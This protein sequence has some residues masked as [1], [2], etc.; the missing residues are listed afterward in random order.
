[1][2]IEAVT[3]RNY[4]AFGSR[5]ARLP[6]D[7]EFVAVTGVNNSGKT[8]ILRFFYEMRPLFQRI[9][10]AGLNSAHMAR[11]LAPAG[12]EV[13]VPTV[14]AGERI[15]CAGNPSA[16]PR[17]TFEFQSS[18][19]EDIAEITLVLRADSTVHAQLTLGSGQ[20]V[21]EGLPVTT[22]THDNRVH[23][24]AFADANTTWTFDW[25]PVTADLTQ[26]AGAMYV[27]GFRN[28]VNAGGI[29]PYYDLSAGT[30]FIARF[31]QM[32]SGHNHASNEAVLQMC[33][34][35]ADIFGFDHLDVN[36]SPAT[37]ELQF[38]VDNSSF[39]GSELGAGITEF[40]IVAA[41]TLA[42]R[43]TM[44]LIDEPELHLHASLQLRFLSLLARY[45]SGPIV[46]STHSLGLARAAADAVMVASRSSDGTA[47]L[48]D[49]RAVPNLSS[50]LGELGYGGLNDGTFQ[51][52]L[53]VE[54][55]TDVR[56]MHEFLVKLGVR[57]QVVIAPLGGDA[58]AAGKNDFGL[59]EL[60]RLS[61]HVFAIVDSER[62]TEADAAAPRRRAFQRSCDAQGIHCHL[63]ERRSI[64]NYLDLA[65]AR[66]VMSA[67]DATDFGPFD[68]P[69]VEWNWSRERNWR[70]AQQMNQD[71]VAT[72][73]LGTALMAIVAQLNL[74]T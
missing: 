50:I 63:L 40:V 13:G 11:L 65:V 24:Q 61:N 44:L 8:S 48:D 15:R 32:K 70:I 29:D 57:N 12:L 72:T 60:R 16:N 69:G 59:S 27:P 73:D 67:P 17:I 66:E 39:R 21:P 37:D 58:L 20:S 7:H 36:A 22:V 74:D 6:L 10:A 23:L 30:N 35:L 9:A 47:T 45:T 41:N 14:L 19:P 28:A 31:N 62:T 56:V 33:R 3:L 43:P 52:V 42:R 34:E 38:N 54:G 51:A 25:A 71:V 55:V 49:W 18:A 68:A 53:L 64:E 2:T 26:L 4:R 1:M 5:G 46:F